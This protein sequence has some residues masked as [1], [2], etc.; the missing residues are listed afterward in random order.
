LALEQGRLKFEVP[1]KAMKIDQHPFAVSMVEISEKKGMGKTKV[2]TS[3][4]AKESGSVGPSAQVL[5][6]EV[7]G[8]KLH[9]EAECSTAQ[10]KRVTSRMLLDKF[11]RD[12]EKQQSKKE[13]MCRKEEH[14]KCPF[15]VHC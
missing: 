9:G 10:Q 12:R 7:K 11:Q 1:K 6:D 3:E 14:W 8:K 13:E 4:S 2:L 5:A 15:F